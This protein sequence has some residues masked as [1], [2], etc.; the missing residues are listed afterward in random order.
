M[1]AAI[2]NH[3]KRTH[4]VKSPNTH[5]AAMWA[6]EE[7]GFHDTLCHQMSPVINEADRN[8]RAKENIVGV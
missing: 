8:T 4:N 7:T 5:Q 3:C 1:L 2:M 6:M